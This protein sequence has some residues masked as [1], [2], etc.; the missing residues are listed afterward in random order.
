[1]SNLRIINVNY[2]DLSASLTASTTAGSLAAALMK[3]DEKGEAHRSTGTSVNYTLTWSS[4]V[5]IGGIAL[6]AT[7][8]SPTA[9]ARVRL[10]SNTGMTTM[11]ADT[12]TVTAC[13]GL[14]LDLALWTLTG[15][16]NANSFAYGGASK[17]SFW[18]T[19]QPANVRACL[20]NLVDT[21]NPAGYIDCARLV[22][23]PYWEPL[24]N[25]DYGASYQLTDDTKNV[26]A[27]SG[28]LYSD[29]GPVNE[30]LS[31][32]LSYLTPSERSQLLKLI[33]GNGIWKPVFLS[34]FPDD[35]TN[36][37]QTYQIYGKR[38]NAPIDH[39]FFNTFT[40][41]LELEGW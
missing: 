7:N 41:P 29:R 2:V 32:K 10:Y 39:P 31:L 19:S 26:R 34:L 20:I 14:D 5:T 23:G 38:K 35:A 21:S 24:T 37:E 11:I 36:L 3:T 1:M 40:A 15:V 9:T 17:S 30:F 4:N 12:G 18:F 8:L 16:R 25:A 6:P 13:P 27:D 28:S 33:R 22:A